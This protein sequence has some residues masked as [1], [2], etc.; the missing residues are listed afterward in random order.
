MSLARKGYIAVAGAFAGIGFYKNYPKINELA[1]S[2]EFKGSLE[3][4]TPD[5]FKN[6]PRVEWDNS[7]PDG[8]FPFK[9]TYNHNEAEKES[10]CNKT[11]GK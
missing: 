6:L 3:K 4:Y 2:N 10:P 7:K 1:Q 11:P 8:A 9:I 5:F